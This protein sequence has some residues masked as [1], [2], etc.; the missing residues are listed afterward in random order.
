M[1]WKLLLMNEGI[2]TSYTL[3]ITPPISFNIHL[4]VVIWGNG[5]LLDLSGGNSPQISLNAWMMDY[6]QWPS[7]LDAHWNDQWH[8]L[9]SVD[10]VQA[11]VFVFTNIPSTNQWN[12]GWETGFLKLV[13]IRITGWLMLHD[14]QVPCLPESNSA[15]LEQGPGI[16][17]FL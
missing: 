16:C 8:I 10:V 1:C 6:K 17:M 12:Q 9:V 11:M 3:E 5:A 13:W 2:R 15:G 4:L 7:I 14:R